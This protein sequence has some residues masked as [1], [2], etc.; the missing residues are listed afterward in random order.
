[1]LEAILDAAQREA[2]GRGCGLEHEPVW[3]IEPIAFDPELVDLAEQLLRGGQPARR[4]GWP[5]APCTTP[6]R[7]REGSPSA[8]VFTPSLEGVSHSPREDTP[9]ADLAVAIEAFGLL[10]NSRLAA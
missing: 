7:W 10:A 6:P 9:E 1:M 4:S 8:M 5:A 3:R 2:R